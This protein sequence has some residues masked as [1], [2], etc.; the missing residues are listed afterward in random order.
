MCICKQ[1]HKGAVSSISQMKEPELKEAK[2]H[3]ERQHFLGGQDLVSAV[4]P[5]EP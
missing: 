2:P 5:W 1:P 3:S 4:N